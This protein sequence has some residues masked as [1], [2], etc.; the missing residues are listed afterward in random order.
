MWK[1]RIGKHPPASFWS[2]LYQHLRNL[3]PRAVVNKGLAQME[4]G[5]SA[6]NRPITLRDAWL[7]EWRNGQNAQDT[8]K[9]TCS[10]DGVTIVPSPG[11]GRDLGQRLARP[12]QKTKRGD[13]FG[14]EDLREV[15][16]VAKARTRVEQLAAR[17]EKAKAIAEKLIEK[18]RQGKAK[19]KDIELLRETLALAGRIKSEHDAAI[20]VYE[21]EVARQSARARVYT[22]P[23]LTRQAAL[24]PSDEG[25]TPPAPEPTR[26]K[27]AP[28]KQS[29][30]GLDGEATSSY[31]AAIGKRTTQTAPPKVVVPQLPPPLPMEA[32]VRTEP[33]CEPCAH[34]KA[35]ATRSPQPSKKADRKASETAP[36][37]PTPSAE[38]TPRAPL[39]DSEA[40]ALA[41]LF[42]AAT[43]EDES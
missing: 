27:A 3:F 8:A 10:C 14:P 24:P 4:I 2:D 7:F 12:P 17:F 41:N 29:S 36:I 19:G 11:A 40:E 1:S 26:K 34:G 18:R 32:Y 25:D 42:A 13:E 38:T 37:A 5:L 28:K 20:D 15:I 23:T 43:V 9:A 16:P 35:K 21:A 6:D 33:T 31:A 30:K 39:S 22:G